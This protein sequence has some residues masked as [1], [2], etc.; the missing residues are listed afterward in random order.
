M[1]KRSSPWAINATNYTSNA[2]CEKDGFSG[3]YWYRVIMLCEQ[4]QEF[5]GS[6]KYP[7]GQA[8]RLLAQILYW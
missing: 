3:Y 2:V 4:E 6:P 1:E 7:H 5:T 8:F